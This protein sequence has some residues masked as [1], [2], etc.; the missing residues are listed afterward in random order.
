MIFA[1]LL[2]LVVWYMLPKAIYLLFSEKLKTWFDPDE[3]AASRMLNLESIRE[4]GEKLEALGFRPLGVKIEKPPLWSPHYRELSYASPQ[5]Q[6]YASIFISRRKTIYYFL[7]VFTSGQVILTA[8]DI[9]PAISEEHFIQSSV[10]EVTPEE[11]LKIH[12]QQ[13]EKFR[14]QGLTPELEY[15]REKRIAATT[16]YYNA[17]LIRKRMRVVGMFYLVPMLIFIVI[18]LVV[19]IQKL[20]S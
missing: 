10:A 7:T 5:A 15:T 13:V 16:Q 18:F 20:K 12:Q 4:V 6:A 14:G 8:N 19:L 2:V 17:A 3:N 9:Y 11:L 1:L